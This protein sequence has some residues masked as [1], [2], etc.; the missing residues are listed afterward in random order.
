MPLDDLARGLMGE[1]NGRLLEGDGVAG[2]VVG[3][4]RLEFA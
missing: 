4:R 1:L 3:V 2:G